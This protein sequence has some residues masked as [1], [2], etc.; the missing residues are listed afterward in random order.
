MRRA[1]ASGARYALIVGDDEAASGLV[2]LK[3]LREAGE[4]QR[5]PLDSLAQALG[6]V[7]APAA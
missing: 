4:Q 3:P 7:A 6:A 1:D 2:S 5:L